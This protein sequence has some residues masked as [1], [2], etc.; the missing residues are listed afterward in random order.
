MEQNAI[1][2]ARGLGD[3]LQVPCYVLDQQRDAGRVML[4]GHRTI[5]I[6]RLRAP[7]IEADL[8]LRDF[9]MNALFLDPRLLG[10]ERKNDPKLAFRGPKNLGHT[11]VIEN[12][13]SGLLQAPGGGECCP[14]W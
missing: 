13:L 14:G 4:S 8:K 12:L 3:A 10:I 11:G 6:A 9:T 1:S 2:L 5:D 7:T